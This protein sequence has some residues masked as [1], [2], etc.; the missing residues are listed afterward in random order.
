MTIV[1]WQQ[2]LQKA[3]SNPAMFGSPLAGFFDRF[4]GEDFFRNDH[5]S[6]MPAVNV[7]KDANGYLLELSAPGF[8]KSDFKVALDKGVLTI[9]AE[10]TMQQE[11]EEPTFYRKEF[12]KGSFKRTFSLPEE[13]DEAAVQARYDNGILKLSLPKKPSAEPALK[14]IPVS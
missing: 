6:F 4:L 13:V 10:H 9:S 5:A 12:T 1:K 14:E 3:N 8:D 7:L 2:P 11:A